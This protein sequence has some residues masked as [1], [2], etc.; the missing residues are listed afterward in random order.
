M[1]GES[2]K[3]GGNPDKLPESDCKHLGQAQPLALQ[4]AK[5]ED[6]RNEILDE[7]WVQYTTGVVE[8][9]TDPE[10]NEEFSFFVS[11]CFLSAHNVFSLSK[12]YGTIKT[13][14]SNG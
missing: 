14:T 3:G 6:C 1:A 7:N 12:C 5:G 2:A 4:V 13:V 9:T 11:R 8:D 10:F